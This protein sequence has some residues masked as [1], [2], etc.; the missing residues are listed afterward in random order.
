REGRPALQVIHTRRLL[1]HSKGDD[2]RP[3]DLID[4]LWRDDPLT[5]LCADSS[6]LADLQEV[7]ARDILHLAEA[8]ATR[9]KLDAA[10]ETALPPARRIR[11][12]LELHAEAAQRPLGRVAE[13]LNAALHQ[14]MEQHP[15]VVLLGEDLLDP[16]GGAFK[17]SKGLSTNYPTQV[18]STP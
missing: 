11:R 17:V 8:V 5:R 12:S 16:Y 13:E 18:F 14:M 7:A 10:G 4:R 1:A 15:E 6:Q 9:P 3:A 2:N